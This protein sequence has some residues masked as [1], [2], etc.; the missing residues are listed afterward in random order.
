L[1]DPQIRAYRSIDRAGV[2]VEG[3]TQQLVPG[4][5]LLLQV[6]RQ[7]EGPVERFRGDLGP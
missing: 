4:L 2:V 5:G 6:R 3:R 7:V 1:V